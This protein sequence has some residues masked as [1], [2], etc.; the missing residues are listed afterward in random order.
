M[1]SIV[2]W[3]LH[4]IKKGSERTEVLGRVRYFTTF[5]GWTAS[6]ESAK[7]LADEEEEEEAEEFSGSSGRGL[8]GVA[9]LV[10]AG[11]MKGVPA[12]PGTKEK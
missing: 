12:L 9:A 3:H 6:N 10:P 2:P 1:E 11:E 5:L 7:T 4:G 8:S